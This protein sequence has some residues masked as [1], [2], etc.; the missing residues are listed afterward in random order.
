MAIEAC[1]FPEGSSLDGQRVKAAWFHD[2]YR[3]PLGKDHRSMADIFFALFGHHPAWVKAVLLTRNRIAAVFGLDVPEA[4]DIQNPVQKASYQVGD[5]I[6]PWPVFS[7]S[8]NELIAGRD[9]RHLDFRL[10]LLREQRAGQW[11]VV[12]STVC[13]VHNLSGRIYLLLNVSFRKWGVKHLM[14][15]A[16]RAGRSLGFSDLGICVGAMRCDCREKVA[17]ASDHEG[18]QTA[19]HP[20]GIG[21]IARQARAQVFFLNHDAPKCGDEMNASGETGCRAPEPERS[22]GDQQIA[23]I[24]RV[25]HEVIDPSIDHML[26]VA[27]LILHV[28]RSEPIFPNSQRRQRSSNHDS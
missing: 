5:L 4:S 10:V 26:T 12:V 20:S 3:A 23:E 1:G 16:V 2:S 21:S 6:G 9:N 24:D 18:Y 19:A 17:S 7:L 8:E 28:R 11:S 13:E 25:T 15:N 27:C 22:T 14:L